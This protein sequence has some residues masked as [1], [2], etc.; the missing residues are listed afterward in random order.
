MPV[1]FQYSK[2]VAQASLE[3][4]DKSDRAPEAGSV[5]DLARA[6]LSR[7]AQA[8]RAE[9]TA[10]PAVS[11]ADLQRFA[12]H[13]VDNDIEAATACVE[14]L[15]RQ[16][17]GYQQIADGL[18]AETA[19]W[20]GACWDRDVLSWLDVSL[21]ISALLRVNSALRDACTRQ[22]RVCKCDALFA[23][24][25]NQSHTL[26]IILAAE[27]FRQQHL[28][29]EL[30]L[31]ASA[32]DIVDAADRRGVDFVGLTVGSDDRLKDIVPLAMRLK[33]LPRAPGILVGGSAAKSA[34]L[35]GPGVP[36]DW[37]VG[38][39]DEATAIA[40]DALCR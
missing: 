7:L 23:T 34:A 19:R 17:A 26:G 15:R 14:A 29:V 30:M 8:R 11:E 21:G 32:G 9:E 6:A 31:G 4:A 25:P 12:G 16:G 35:A 40:R 38:S 2:T 36:V 3:T 37:T 24:L 28:D 1:Q 18:F 22:C 39:L 20:L 10:P 27:A 33:A 5:E 13:L